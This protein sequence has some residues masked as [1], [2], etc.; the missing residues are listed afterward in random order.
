MPAFLFIFVK[1]YPQQKPY[2]EKLFTSGKIQ[3]KSILDCEPIKSDLLYCN[4][5]LTY[6]TEYELPKVL[7]KFKECKMLVAIHNT[8]EDIIAAKK[9]GDE[10]ITCNKTRLI[11]PRD[12]WI[13]KF[14]ANGFNPEY[15]NRTQC[16]YSIP[17]TR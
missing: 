6:F 9:Q 14:K 3:I 10:L 1:K 11:K 15:D 4:G 5:T 16:F 12:W 17:K 7:N 2:L 13:E 8:T